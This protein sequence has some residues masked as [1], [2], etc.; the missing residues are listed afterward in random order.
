VLRIDRFG[1]VVTNLRREDL[2]SDFTMRIAGCVVRRI[3]A[4]F[5]EGAPGEVFALEG[6][7]GYIELAL[8]QGSAAGRL[9]LQ[10]G[11]EIEVESGTANH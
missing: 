5:S 1:N 4:T 3:C 8:N 9:R 2:P 7:T 6:S 11:A 10:A